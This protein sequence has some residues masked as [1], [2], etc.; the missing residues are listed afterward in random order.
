LAPAASAEALLGGI[1]LGAFW[2][3]W[4]VYATRIGMDL[5]GESALIS[6]TMLGGALLQLPI[7]RLSDRGDR[8]TA[9]AVIC[10]LGAA[11]AVAI[12]LSA[13][14][15]AWVL[16]GLFFAFGGLLFATYPIC[17]AHLLDYL[18]SELV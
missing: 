8:R 16:L 7:G 5:A 4:A 1:G 17:V 6:M 13:G 10:T 14:A 9:L 18:P 2:G 12:M 11:L 3:M 15:N